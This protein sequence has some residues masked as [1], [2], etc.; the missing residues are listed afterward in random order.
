MNL[1][2]SPQFPCRPA[3]QLNVPS[4][5]LY[6]FSPDRDRPTLVYDHLSQR[7]TVSLLKRC[8]ETI[9]WFTTP[10]KI[11]QKSTVRYFR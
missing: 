6:Y 3:I 10:L 2:D 4:K 11:K 7:N 8:E 5:R 1:S 9:M